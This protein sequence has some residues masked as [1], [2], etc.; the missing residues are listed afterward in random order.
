M[1]IKTF[2]A[3]KSLSLE[4]LVIVTGQACTLRC[5]D[6]GNFAPFA[7]EAMKSY[8]WEDLREDVLI[9]FK[10]IEKIEKVIIQGGEPFLY[11]KLTDLI[12][13]IYEARKTENIQIDTNGTLVPSSDLIE[14][15]KQCKVI[16]RIS[17]YAISSPE[18]KDNQE[19]IINI[20]SENEIP[21]KIYQFGSGNSTWFDSGTGL[22]CD[23]S[24]QAAK[25]R[26]ESCSFNVCLTLENG[27]IGYCSRSI[28]AEIVQEIKTK[29]GD[30]VIVRN[31]KNLKEELYN[32][33]NKKKYMEACKYCYGTFGRPTISAA[34]QAPPSLKTYKDLVEFEKECNTNMFKKNFSM[35]SIKYN[36]FYMENSGGGGG[37]WINGNASIIIEN[38][39]AKHFWLTGFYPENWPANRLIV[40]INNRESADIDII[41]GN[42]FSL[43]LDFENTLD[44]VY[45]GL[46]TE[47]TFIPKD[48]GWNDDTRKLGAYIISWSLSELIPAW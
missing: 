9:V 41:S 3:N 31:N 15:I 4:R 33:V 10:E 48:E 20:L 18:K 38:K 28:I 24:D 29:Q 22:A 11:K 14:C 12:Y 36:G 26:F 44:I 1:F 30:Y 19:K 37:G 23:K 27:K 17:D 35:F 13:L 2:P 42:S 39:I 7:P 8:L 32:Y 6:C 40:T 46:K 45:I 47:K 21:Y 43:K 16:V 5:R 25:A 34:I